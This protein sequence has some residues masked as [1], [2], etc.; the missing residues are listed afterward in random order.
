M[1]AMVV[2]GNARMLPLKIFE[3]FEYLS[4]LSL[5]EGKKP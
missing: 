5:T 1:P 2:E 4:A 3:K